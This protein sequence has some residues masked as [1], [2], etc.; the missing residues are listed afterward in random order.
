MKKQA[1]VALALASTMILASCTQPA[2]PAPQPA[3]PAPP[4]ATTPE[5]APTPAEP[6]V[7]EPEEIRGTG[8]PI[9]IYSNS[10][11][12]LFHDP[13]E[14]L[15]AEYG[16][17]VRSVFAGGGAITDRLIA[18]RHNPTANIVY[19]LNV[20][21]RHSLIVNDVI[22]PH[23][24]AWAGVYLPRELDHP[25]GFYHATDTTAIFLTYDS[26]QLSPD[27]APT[28][29]PDLWNDERF[30][31]LYQFETALIGGTTRMVLSGILSR[32]LDPNGHLGVSDEGWNEIRQFYQYGIPN[33][34]AVDL[35]AQMVDPNTTVIMGQ[36]H[37][38]GI[39]SREE[40][41]GITAGVVIPDVGVPLVIEALALTSNTTNQEEAK[42]FL[43]WLT[44]ER[45]AQIRGISDPDPRFQNLPVQIMDWNTVAENIEAWVEHIY[46]TYLP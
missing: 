18:E 11:A 19:G 16:F 7:T 14:A 43:D 5:P 26:T 23:E 22:I 36:L 41:Y 3:T 12:E 40:Q 6:S 10:N 9:Y 8:V 34:G 20:F 32:H 28:D 2:A 31:G 1:L 29:W 27:E 35:F 15:A 45:V 37:D 4:A 42:R 24:P 38:G 33:T 39:P 30:H 21:L 13:L 25:Q 46:L 17:V 44:P